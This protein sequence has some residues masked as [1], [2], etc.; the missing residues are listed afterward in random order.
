MERYN[1][2]RIALLT[3]D[4]NIFRGVSSKMNMTKSLKINDFVIIMATYLCT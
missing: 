2:T 4:E 3:Q 1:W